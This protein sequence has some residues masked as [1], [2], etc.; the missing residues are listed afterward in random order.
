M[1]SDGRSSESPAASAR[2]DPG[3]MRA[4]F[5]PPKVDLYG[6]PVCSLTM[7]QMVA[8]L[9]DGAQKRQPVNVEALNAGKVVAL[10]KDPVL[11]DSLKQADAILPDGQSIVW[12]SHILGQRVPE[13]VPGIDLM[14]ATL[15]AAEARGFSAF[16]LGARDDVLQRAVRNIKKRHPSLKIAG[17]HHGYFD[18]HDEPEIVELIN[19]SGAD[20]LYLG[21]S[22]P[23]KEMWAARH[24]R[25]LGV[26]VVLGVGGSFEVLAG[27]IRRA[28]QRMRRWGMEWLYRFLNEPGRMWRRY[29]VGNAVFIWLTALEATH[30]PRL[31]HRSW[32]S[33]DG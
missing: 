17:A 24:T 7:D 11:R 30:S 2:P 4:R 29:L 23:K 22:S 12:A 33:R 9:V 14:E 3:Q 28:P 16:L 8:W 32:P 13:R 10:R 31:D 6:L 20:F 27:D 18:E 1:M 25:S 21:I 5:A 15:A 26:S 19:S